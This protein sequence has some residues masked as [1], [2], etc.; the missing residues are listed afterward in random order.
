MIAM[1]DLDI[2][3]MYAYQVNTA[4]LKMSAFTL[5]DSSPD[6]SGVMWYEIAVQ[7]TSLQ[8]WIESQPEDLWCESIYTWGK[9]TSLPYLVHESLYTYITLRWE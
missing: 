8:R 3:S 5:I 9:Q 6:S 7:V 2:N 1:I 4:T